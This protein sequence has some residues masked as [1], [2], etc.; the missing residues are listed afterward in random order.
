[1]RF[2]TLILLSVFLTRSPLIA[3]D[4]NGNGV[5]DD[6]DIAS[7]TSDDCDCN[8]VPDECDGI[9]TLL[10]TSFESGL[11]A[12][13]SQ[14]DDA[15]V[16]SS[17]PRASTC[18]GSKWA[19]IGEDSFCG[20][21]VGTIGSIRTPLFSAPPGATALRLTYCSAY[22]ASQFSAQVSDATGFPF[23]VDVPTTSTDWQTR[24]VYL[25]TFVERLAFDAVSSGPST[26]GLGWMIDHVRIDA[27]F[28]PNCDEIGT[29]FCSPAVVNSTGQPGVMTVLGSET[30]ADD[31]LSL[32][33]TQ[34]PPSSNIGY[35]IM[36]TGTNTFVPTGSA[37]PI[38]VAPGIKRFL[39]PVN[40]TSQLSGGFCRAVGTTGPVS[41]AITPGSTW[42]FQ[43]WHRDGMALSNL[44]DAVA[45]TFQ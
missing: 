28:G 34:L 24:V 37:G 19:Y 40:N 35:F 36:G 18:D 27:V 13:W 14:F 21:V 2:A 5:S 3:Q 1:M 9:V 6:Q 32:I 39:P 20:V 25:D 8:G 31:A 30:V 42:S 23:P 7:G 45:V 41:S 12:G 11:P 44:T 4:C 15:H 10:E 17:C 16:T 22:Q 33:A 43:A 38:C 26:S 29:R